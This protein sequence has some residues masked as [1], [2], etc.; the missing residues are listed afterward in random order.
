MIKNPF[1][2]A[3]MCRQVPSYFPSPY[4]IAALPIQS[5]GSSTYWFY[6]PPVSSC[7]WTPLAVNGA[8]N[9]EYAT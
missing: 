6:R 1:S 3:N 4:N 9:G 8:K 7:L 2:A 5:P